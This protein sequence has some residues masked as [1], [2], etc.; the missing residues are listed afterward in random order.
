MPRKKKHLNAKTDSIMDSMQTKT[1]AALFL[2]LVFLFGCTQTTNPEPRNPGNGSISGSQVVPA[3]IPPL[4]DN[5]NLQEFTNNRLVPQTLKGLE[6]DPLDCSSSF[7]PGTGNSLVCTGAFTNDSTETKKLVATVVVKDSSSGC[8]MKCDEGYELNKAFLEIAPNDDR[9][10]D[11][12]C[13][14]NSFENLKPEIVL[15]QDD[16]MAEGIPRCGE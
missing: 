5:N 2:L 9:E 4:T 15:T 6:I 8:I 10:I 7:I 1:V 13:T 12:T 16:Y 14:L 3:G 11:F